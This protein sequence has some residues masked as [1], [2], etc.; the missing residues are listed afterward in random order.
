MLFAV[1]ELIIIAQ[2]SK[3]SFFVLQ[4]ADKFGLSSVNALGLALKD[5]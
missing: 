1:E 2:H 5:G 3:F 4:F